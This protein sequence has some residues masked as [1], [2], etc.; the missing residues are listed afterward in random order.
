MTPFTPRT[1]R[2]VL[3]LLIAAIVPAGHARA[4]ASRPCPTGAPV[5]SFRLLARPVGGGTVLPLS[6]LS[7]IR[8]GETLVYDPVGTAL[9]KK[10]EIAL[11]VIGDDPASPPRILKAKS[12][13]GHA[14]WLMPIRSAAVGVVLGPHGIDEKKL[15][16]VLRKDPAAVDRL[17][18]YADQT[19]KVEALV[20]ALSVYEQSSPGSGNL[21]SVLSGFSSQY[22]VSLP[23]LDRSKPA[24]QQASDLLRAITP[25]FSADS[26]RPSFMQQSGGLAASVASMFFGAPVGLAIGGAAL[27][28]NL[29]SSMFPP[30]DFQSAFTEN[31]T[32]DALTLC[33]GN[34]K[35]DPRV[36][37]EYV[38]MVRLVD[39]RRPDSC[40]ADPAHVPIGWTSTLTLHCRSVGELKALPHARNW[41]LVSADGT[42]VVP[43]AL[44][45][46]EE[47]D[48]LA[49]DLKKV[50]I[51]PGDYRLAATWDWSELPVS[52]TVE[53]RRFADLSAVAIAPESQDRL[54]A[55]AGPVTIELTGADFEFVDR[56]TLA[57]AAVAGQP[58]TVAFALPKGKNGGEQ[59]TV[60]ATLDA[61]ALKPGRYVLALTQSNGSHRDVPVTVHAA[62]PTLT[63]LPLKANVGELEQRIVLHGTALERIERIT[64]RGTTW[65]LSPVLGHNVTERPARIH[66]DADVHAGDRIALALGVTGLH[67]PIALAGALEAIGPRPKIAGAKASVARSGGVELH[68]GE[69]P[70]GAPVSFA[71]QTDGAGP[72]PSLRLG[73]DGAGGV[74]VA[75]GQATAAATFNAIGTDD[76]F[77][78]ID[79]G[80]IGPSGCTLTAAIVNEATGASDPFPLGRVIRL[81]R[82]DSFT[83]GSDAIGK[84]LYAGTLTGE[85]LETVEKTGWN[86]EAGAP[87]QGIATPVPG[88][89]GKQTLTIAVPWP[90]PSPHAPL[91][92]WLRGEAKGR[93]SGIRY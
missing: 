51:A 78:S 55:G 35:P 57:N 64:G 89:P 76:W 85:G 31:G 73:C 33:T 84:G 26:S 67:E 25:A 83:I 37:L 58:A 74:T 82:I 81:P 38:W 14:E 68:D 72:R 11:I 7:V 53:V 47:S 41:R 61:D 91:Y 19:T 3:A 75:V 50:T 34:A 30:T 65:R 44:T 92:V 36:R 13:A 86:A 27:V 54:I 70:A 49:I 2:A 79:P 8:P 80:A 42:V 43:A 39:V 77:L 45:V 69:L 9:R 63:G 28:G 66:L 40:A 62:N 10:S 1:A 90:P 12:A 15:A 4:A 18:E 60:T 93:L 56:M 46:G 88:S 6:Y 16:A 32:A 52:G 23:A 29:H 24:D 71:M 17:A 21:Q 20:Q 87:V 22:G 48:Q 59:R 5:A